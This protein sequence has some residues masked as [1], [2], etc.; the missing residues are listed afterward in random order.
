MKQN[1][2][3]LKKCKVCSNTN[4][5]KVLTLQEQYLSPTFVKSNKN[6][7]LAD[8]RSPLTLVLCDKTKNKNNCGLLQLLEITEPDLLYKQYFYRSATNDTMKS[9]LN[10]LVNQALD[11]ARPDKGDVI[12][13]IGSNDCTLLNFYKN[14]FNLIGFE[15]AQNIKYIDQ[16]NNI[17]VINNYFNS[18][19][20][21]KKYKSKA[22]IITSCAMFYDLENPRQFVKDIEEILEDDGIWCCQISYLA[23]MIKYNNFYDICHEHL[24]YYSLETFE[25]LIDQFNLKCFYAETNE[26]N[27]GSI[28]LYICKKSSKKYKESKYL[29]KLQ[30]IKIDEQK[31]KLN[32]P[33]TFFNFEK[34]IKDLKD[35]TVK[36]VD[37][38]LNSNKKIL[39]LGASTKGNIILQHF[40]LT[41]E[42]IPYISERNP[43]KVGLKCLGSDIELISE[44]KARDI[45]PDAFIVLPWNFKKEVIKREKKYLENGGKLMFVMPYPHVVTKDKEIKL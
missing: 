37:N 12:V 13:D 5:T 3:S 9:D 10:N 42:K 16:G 20:F 23:S 36:F 17:T 7:K 26:V 22:K 25:Y 39:A 31:F 33:Q 41:K 21:K 44:D 19:E 18:N 27:G 28:R 11:I 29:N 4:L 1:I 14:E 32:D 35:K 24:S 40:G 6:N 8:I 2:K 38:I 30:S 34:I 15:P 45:N 43:D